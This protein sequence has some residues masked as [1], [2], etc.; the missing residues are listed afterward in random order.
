MT[1]QVSLKNAYKSIDASARLS[2]WDTLAP[3][4]CAIGQDF[5]LGVATQALVVA[6]HQHHNCPAGSIYIQQKPVVKVVVASVPSG[7][8]AITPYPA[9]VKK[10]KETNHVH[11]TIGTTPPVDFNIEKPDMTMLHMIEFWRMRRVSEKD[12]ANMVISMVDVEYS[13][14]EHVKGL[15]KTLIVKVPI[16]MPCKKVKVGDELVLH[17]PAK[18]KAEKTEKLLPVRQEPAQKKQKIVD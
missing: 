11:L 18:Q 3:G 6:M 15:P 4:P 16:A 10:G 7:K 1:D 14:P 13:L 12:H 17:I 2:M 9:V 5:W 8:L